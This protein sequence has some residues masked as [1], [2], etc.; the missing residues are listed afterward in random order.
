LGRHWRLSRSDG[1]LNSA[2]GRLGFF[3]DLVLKGNHVELL[4]RS[5]SR[6]LLLHVRLEHLADLRVGRR[7][8]YF[9]LL[10]AWGQ[11]DRFLRLVRDGLRGRDLPIVGSHRAS[12]L[13]YRKA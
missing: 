7:I 12:L 1:S 5:A 9:N 3:V 11:F 6:R 4:A 13:E 10:V 2:G 8:D